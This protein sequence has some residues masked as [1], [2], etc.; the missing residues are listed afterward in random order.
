VTFCGHTIARRL[1]LQMRLEDAPRRRQADHNLWAGDPTCQQP[2][3][4]VGIAV[5]R[6]H[7]DCLTSSLANSGVARQSD[8]EL[9]G[10]HVR[11][12]PLDSW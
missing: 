7:D 8:R 12:K 9:G 10:D 1:S 2:G 6:D 5:N 3:S 11:A 4:A